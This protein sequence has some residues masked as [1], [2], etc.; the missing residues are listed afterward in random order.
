METYG[1]A[2]EMSGA[3][4]RIEIKG[5][6]GTWVLDKQSVLA[7][8]TRPDANS[9]IVISAKNDQSGSLERPVKGDAD[10]AL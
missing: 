3:A 9:E 1:L 2:A 10:M 8:L 6:Q 7:H 5:K 4:I